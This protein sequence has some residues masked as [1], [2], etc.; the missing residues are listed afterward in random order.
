MLLAIIRLVLTALIGY[1][2]GS[3]PS[4]VIVGKLYGV[5]VLAHGSGHT[6]ATNVLRT[7][8]GKAAAI[9]VLLDIA[10]GALA[11]LL[12]RFLLFPASANPAGLDLALWAEPIAGLAAI[13]GHNFSLFLRFKGG[14]GVATG[15]GAAL[16]MNPLVIAL[17]LPLGALP[18][19]L[20]RYVSLG[21]MTAAAVC[22]ISELVF[23]LTRIDPNWAH[24]TYMLVGGVGI[25][26]AH[27]DNIGRLLNGTERKFGQKVT[28]E[29][30][31]ASDTPTS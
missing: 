4:G 2:A 14:R 13:L 9:V 23:V 17:A 18:V 12:A 29:A 10:K 8:G 27:Y 1:L 16:A 25:I 21:S 3:F 22:A 7:A 28:A 31:P 19:A 30:K 5:D 15:G 26:A 11:V 24:F 6:G 20:T